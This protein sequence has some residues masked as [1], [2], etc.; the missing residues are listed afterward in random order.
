MEL[1]PAL[2][3]PEDLGPSRAGRPA[4][5]LERLGKE[6]AEWPGEW[7]DPVGAGVHCLKM[8]LAVCELGE[9]LQM[10]GLA[11]SRADL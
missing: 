10:E 4:V 1:G 5:L 6:A 9:A 8:A 11:V 7:E 3:K 2:T